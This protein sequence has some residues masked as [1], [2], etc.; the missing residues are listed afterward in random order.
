M[1]KFKVKFLAAGTVAYAVYADSSGSPGARLAQQATPQTVAAGWNTL[2]ISDVSI[3][4]GN[5]Y[6]LSVYVATGNIGYNT[7]GGT[8]K[9]KAS[10]STFPDPFDNTG[11]TND[12]IP[13]FEAGWGIVIP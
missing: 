4:S 13:V 2:A 10:A 7:S 1:T 9:Y 3:T 8:R 12:S 11:F 5:Y 6:W